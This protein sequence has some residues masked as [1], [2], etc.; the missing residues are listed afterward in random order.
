MALKIL[1]DV[2]VRNV[3]ERYINSALVP[4]VA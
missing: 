3:A 2:E 4:E 1:E